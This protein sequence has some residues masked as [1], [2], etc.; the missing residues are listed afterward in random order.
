MTRSLTTFFFCKLFMKHDQCAICIVKLQR[1][2][3]PVEFRGNRRRD[4]GRD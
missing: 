4:A 1:E 2:S 3:L